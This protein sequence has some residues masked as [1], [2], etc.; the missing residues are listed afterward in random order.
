MADTRVYVV[1]V[2]GGAEYVSINDAIKAAV[3]GDTVQ[4]HMGQYDE[5]ILLD[6]AVNIVPEPGIEVLDV[7]VTGGAVCTANG[8]ISGISIQQLVDIR[9]GRPTLRNCDLSLGTDGVRVCTG[10][11]ATL[12]D[13]RIHGS[14]SG[15]DGVY[16]QEGGKVTISGCEL[17]HHRVNAIHVNGGEAHVTTS[18]IHDCPFGVY[19]R[20][21]GKG[22]VESN[23]ID[24]VSRF[25]VYLVQSSDPLVT[26]NTIMNCG[27]SGIMIAQGALGQIKDNMVHAT[28]RILRGCAPTLGANTINGHF[29]NENNTPAVGTTGA[30]LGEPRP[31]MSR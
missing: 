10:S 27:V 23:T 21:G 20:K 13:C 7:V 30:A 15:G 14:Q 1:N 22:L 25:G 29:D 6:R 5:V 19:F 16:V 28:V 9:Q 8:S 2:K 3:D 18:K 11:D 12:Q 24:N 26:K 17:F 4:V 31:S